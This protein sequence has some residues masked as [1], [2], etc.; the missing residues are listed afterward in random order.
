MKLRLKQ[1][2]PA[3]ERVAILWNA[4]D[5][6][7]TLR[8]RASETGAKALGVAVQPLGSREPDRF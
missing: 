5:L 8:Y 7:M 4:G 3:L 1:I 2:Y 6:G